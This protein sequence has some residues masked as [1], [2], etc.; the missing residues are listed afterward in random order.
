[1]LKLSLARAGKSVFHKSPLRTRGADIVQGLKFS[2]S[3]AFPRHRTKFPTPLKVTGGLGI[4]GAVLY[5]TNQIF[6]DTTKNTISICERV[7][8]VTVATFRCFKLYKDA[9]D[10]EYHT[11]RDRELA[12][13]RTHKRAAYI[14][15]KALETNGGIFIKLG[16]HITALT[17][18]LPEEWTSTMIPLQDRCPQSTIEEIREMFKSDLDVSLDEMFSDFS[19]EPVGVASL[20]QVHMATLRNTGQKV[21]VKVQH[22]SLKKFVPLDVKLTQLVFA[23]MYKVFPEYPLTWLG[24]EMQSSIF[25][26]LDFTNEARNAQRTDEFFKNRRSITAL[27]IP[28]I[29]S[30]NKRILIMECVI[31][32]RLDNIQ[33]LKTNKIDPAEVSS[34]LSHI[35]NSMIFEPGASLHCDPHGGNLAIRALPKTQSKNGHNFEIVLYDH[36]LYRDIPLE[37]K[38]D[39]SHFW[40]AVLDKNVPEMKKYAEKFAGIEGEQKFKIFLSAITGRDP[41]TAMNYDISSRRTEQESASIQT[42]LHSTE[43]ALEDLMS[44]LSHMPK[45]VL[46]IL[47]TNDLTRHLDEDLKSPL[48]PE[49]T[50]LILARYCAE[51]VYLE[52]KAQIPLSTKKYSLGWLSQTISAWWSYQKRLN[53]LLVY[54]VYMMFANFR[55]SFS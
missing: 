7:G 27:R 48:G 36:G 30:A 3:K 54:D 22:P 1:M 21:A 14:T 28:Q 18:L 40:L 13:K 26:E 33:Y 46:L 11:P 17:Y 23:L 43:G 37:M 6:H 47:K 20:A 39:Y 51:T 45:I 29:V 5:F 55:K 31:G 32:S 41:N 24:D 19:V 52:A 12:L 10:A 15:L 8:V 53:S 16:Q 2:S 42:Q 35:F 34:C 9:L 50:F 25:V 49:R 44:I 38:R 4:T